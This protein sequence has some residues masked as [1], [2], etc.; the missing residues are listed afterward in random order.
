MANSSQQGNQF[1][2]GGI[3]KA[4]SWLWLLGGI[5]LMFYGFVLLVR[6]S[7][8]ERQF[9]YLLL[10]IVLSS[11]FSA[12]ATIGDHRFRVPTMSMSLI[13]QFIGIWKLKEKMFKN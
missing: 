12:I 7:S 10:L 6:E 9:A 2:N 1:I 4:V 8:L 3:G 13:L 11:W 5:F